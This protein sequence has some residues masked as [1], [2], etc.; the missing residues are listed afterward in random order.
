MARKKNKKSG[1]QG[2]NRTRKHAALVCSMAD[3]TCQAME[4]TLLPNP[5][6]NAFPLKSV[7]RFGIT[8]DATHGCAAVSLYPRM[9]DL[10]ALPLSWSSSE[11]LNWTTSAADDSNQTVMAAAINKY[12]VVGG[13]VKITVRQADNLVKGRWTV[14]SMH[15]SDPTAAPQSL[16]DNQFD[17]FQ[18]YSQD[19]IDG[20]EF[21][22]DIDDVEAQ[23]AYTNA[24]GGTGITGLLGMVFSCQGAATS[25]VVADVEVTLFYDCEPEKGSIVSLL[26]PP[27][28]LRP[29]T[30]HHRIAADIHRRKKGHAEKR[31]G[32][33]LGKS[34]ENFAIDAVEKAGPVLLE[35]GVE[36]LSGLF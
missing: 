34:I 14:A 32:K 35:K 7:T 30:A 11:T 22:F 5:K 21:R 13:R 19:E 3:P 26:S 17:S 29:S 6:V 8:T 4:G 25:K 28:G 12:R 2:R 16:T 24:G 33:S 9:K 10:Y 27:S 36:F 31:K 15:A 1:R 23:V 18:T 20:I